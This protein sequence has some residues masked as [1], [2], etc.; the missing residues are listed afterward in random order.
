MV[1]IRVLGRDWPLVEV[2]PETM[3]RLLRIPRTGFPVYICGDRLFPLPPSAPNGAP[4]ELIH[5]TDQS[6]W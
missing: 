1:R 4:Y 3:D 6:P 5:D 2:S